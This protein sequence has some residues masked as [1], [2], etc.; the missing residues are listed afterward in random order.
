[1]TPSDA[2]ELKKDD[3]HVGQVHDDPI[4]EI[5]V[6]EA[7]TRKFTMGHRVLV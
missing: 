6:L 3:H 7:A 4:N 1:M 2:E 5:F